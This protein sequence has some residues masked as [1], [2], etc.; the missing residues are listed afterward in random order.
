M[1]ESMKGI[2]KMASNMALV[3]I[4]QLLVNLKR[5]SGVKAKEWHGSVE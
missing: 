3:Y 4:H 1:V 5:E 2:G